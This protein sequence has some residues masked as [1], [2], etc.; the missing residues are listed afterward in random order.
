MKHKIN[1]T[2]FVSLTFIMIFLAFPLQTASADMGPKPTAEF[3]FVYQTNEPLAIVEAALIECDTSACLD[4]RPLEELGPQNF[5]CELGR[6]TSMAYGYA[7]FLYLEIT[8]SD[9]MTRKSNV[10]GKEH[11]DALYEV[12]V[13]PDDM[14]VVETGGQMNEMTKILA[15]TLGGICLFGLLLAG[16]LVWLIKFIIKAKQKL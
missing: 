1:F 13:Y 16:G 14:A 9:G 3:D 4:P 6:C 15:I 8:F 11:F 7:E 10:F 2:K 12:T 5:S